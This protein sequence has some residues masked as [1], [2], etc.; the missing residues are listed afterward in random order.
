MADPIIISELAR[1]DIIDIWDY[2]IR[3]WSEEQAVRY[4]NGMMNTCEVI[5]SNP[6]SEGRNRDNIRP[7]LKSTIYGKHVIFYRIVGRGKVRIVRI[8]HERMDFTRHF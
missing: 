8:L 1:K 2:T 7:G 3:E 6:E 4:Y 5:A